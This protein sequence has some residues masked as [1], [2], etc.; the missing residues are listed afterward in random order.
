MLNPSFEMSL[1]NIQS[2]L[3]AF[4]I[5]LLVLMLLTAT[6]YKTW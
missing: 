2:A 4:N 6:F 1:A 3:S 5:S